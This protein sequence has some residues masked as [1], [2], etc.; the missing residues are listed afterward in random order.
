MKAEQNSLSL[1]RNVKIG[2]FHLGSGIADVLTTGVWNRIMISDFGFSATP[3]ALLLSLRYFLTPIGIWSGEM[4]DRHRLLGTRRLAWIWTGRLLMTI[5]LLM[6][7]WQTAEIARKFAH[8]GSAAISREDWIVF[9]AALLL[10]SFGNALSGSTF[11]AFLYDRAPQSQRGQVVGI[12]WTFLLFGFMVAGIL[13][14][15]LIPEESDELFQLTPSTIR[16]LFFITG[17]IVAILWLLSLVGEERLSLRDRSSANTALRQGHYRTELKFIWQQ[18][19]LRYFVLFLVFSFTF[20]FFQDIVLEPFAGDVFDLSNEETARFSAYWGGMS[21]LSTLLALFSLRKL[22]RVRHIWLASW[23]TLLLTLAIAS[24]AFAALL[25]ARVFL[26][27]GL[28]ILG[29]GLGV[30]NVGT[31]GLMMDFSPSDRAGTFMGIWTVIITISR[32]VGVFA[33]G[34]VRD[35][36]HALGLSLA[37]SYG[38]LFLFEALGITVS[39]FLLMQVK[40]QVRDAP[41]GASKSEVGIVDLA[42]SI[43]S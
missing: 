26:M 15:V 16:S 34:M 2:L 19:D 13:F 33:G 29:V 38:T 31:L 27:P 24:F 18:A 12:V 21:I 4:S 9:A 3:V 40:E 22:E 20:V 36:L 14:G 37:S 35:L 41:F 25:D 43:E 23:G 30:W 42:K 10:F 39:W 8:L 1:I 7:G 17:G 28:I 5:G 11:L 6:T 32:G